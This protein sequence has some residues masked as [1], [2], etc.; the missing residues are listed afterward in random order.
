MRRQWLRLRRLLEMP[1][2]RRRSWYLA[3][4]FHLRRRPDAVLQ[5]LDWTSLRRLISRH[6]FTRP[7][8]LSVYSP[9]CIKVGH[10]T[11]SSQSQIPLRYPASEPAR[12]LVRELVCDLLASWSA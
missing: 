8:P 7:P 11:R 3:H 4:L 5:A 10:V 2:S 6:R 1:I 9:T 12:E